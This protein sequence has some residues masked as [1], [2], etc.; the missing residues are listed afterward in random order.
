MKQGVNPYADPFLSSGP[1]LRDGPRLVL[2]DD[3][4]DQRV[5]PRATTI[6]VT[7]A[8]TG[9][10]SSPHFPQ[11]VSRGSTVERKPDLTTRPIAGCR[12]SC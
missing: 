11:R 9:L 7:T 10:P 4:F 5:E 12:S 8:T 3:L 6:P 2:D 1:L